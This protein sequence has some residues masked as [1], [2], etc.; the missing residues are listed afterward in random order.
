VSYKGTGPALTAILSGEVQFALLNLAGVLTQIRAG[1]LNPLGVASTQR[2]PLAPDL[3]T[4]REA[5]VDL[6]SGTWYGVLAPRGTPQHAIDV[7]NR[8]INAL[9]KAREFQEQLASRGIVA[10]SMTPQEFSGFVRAEIEKWGGVMK[11]AGIR[12]ED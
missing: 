11:D 1:K 6:V 3:S 10:E 2:S 9:L 7:L 8:E 5:G 4:M 12:Q